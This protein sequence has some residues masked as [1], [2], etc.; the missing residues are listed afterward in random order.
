MSDPAPP[1]P[2]AQTTVVIPF[3]GDPAETAELVSRLS[4]QPAEQVLEVLIC[5]DCSPTPFPAEEAQA[6]GVR[7]LRRTRNGGFGAAVNTAL[8]EVTTPL[9]LV[10]NS[11]V[12][13]TGP[14][15]SE[16]IEAVAGWQPVVASPQIIHADGTGQ[17]AG[18]HFPTI[19]HQTV[20]WLTPLARFRHR[21]HE[22]VGH[23][24]AAAEA[25][26]ITAVDWVMG[27]VM[28]LP[29]AEV[30]A[31]GGFD[32]RYFM[33]SEEVDLQR[34]L[35]ARGIASVVVPGVR[36]VHTGG[37][38]SPAEHRR[39]WVVDSRLRYAQKWG[40]TPGVRRLRTALTAA[41][42]TNF[43]VNLLRRARGREVSPVDVLRTERRLLR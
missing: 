20:E 15:I 30:R 17:W 7:L 32:E 14:Q 38:S 42:W 37:G 22:L 8:A 39:E 10:L 4:Q 9:A 23:D 2:S 28:L 31:V 19:L 11:D 33:N 25:E 16:L 24:T 3:H 35:R 1:A 12:E 6:L 27:A 26:Q 43:A 29:V 5:D 18:R 41:T 13:I 34:R 21:L 36:V 40:G